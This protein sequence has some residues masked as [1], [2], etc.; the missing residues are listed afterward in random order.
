ML[1]NEAMEI[2]SLFTKYSKN[3]LSVEGVITELNSF[4]DVPNLESILVD[5]IWIINKDY[6]LILKLVDQGLITYQLLIERLDI[7]DLENMDFVDKKFRK[8]VARYNTDMFY[9][10]TKFN[11]L[12]EESEGYSKL[13]VTLFE[14]FV[15]PMD[16]YWSAEKGTD[17]QS[18]I[19]LRNDNISRR[20]KSVWINIQKL[21]GVFDLDPHRVLDIILDTFM[22]NLTDHWE[23]FIQLFINSHWKP[24]IDVE[25]KF[26]G[27][28]EVAQILGFKLRFYLKEKNDT[29]ASLFLMSA[30]LIKYR[31]VKLEHLYSHLDF[32]G[33]ILTDYMEYLASIDVKAKNATRFIVPTV[34]SNLI[35]VGW[36]A[37][38]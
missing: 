21:I 5:I 6:N 24:R 26:V 12:R 8:K 3:E 34:I 14:Q 35:E 13:V 7:E 22:V 29:P 19:Q 16:I 20:A 1:P 28:A 37:R 31:I 4:K 11:L 23:F 27:K 2:I 17:M 38:G 36:Y 30:L 15:P 18:L 25:N 32:D 10:Q 33:D 9:R